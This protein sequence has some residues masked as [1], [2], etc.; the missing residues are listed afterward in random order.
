MRSV[1]PTQAPPRRAP[2]PLQSRFFCTVL[3]FLLVAGC[4]GD[5]AERGYGLAIETGSIH[6]VG[7]EEEFEL[8]AGEAAIIDTSDYRV[9]F[10]EI[11]AD[12]RCPEGVQCPWQGDAEVVLSVVRPEQ[13]TLDLVVNIGTSADA[14]PI[15]GGYSL[16]VLQLRPP[17]REQERIPPDEYVVRLAITGQSTAR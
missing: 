16:R 2:R 7:L 5:G 1:S 3:G 6:R 10:V 11:R 15:G 17:A 9:Q 8:G 13:D 12:S 14:H 4:R